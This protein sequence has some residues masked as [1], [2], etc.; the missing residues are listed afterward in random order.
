[1]NTYTDDLTETADAEETT[2][3]TEAEASSPDDT[4]AED[5]RSSMATLADSVL[6]LP[7]TEARS[8]ALEEFDR[9]FLTAALARNSGNIARTARS[10]GLHRQSLQK[11]MAR[12]GIKSGRL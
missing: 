3:S 4:V 6:M 8:R 9:A 11:L 10:L 2:E 7:F 12:R 1:M 5:M